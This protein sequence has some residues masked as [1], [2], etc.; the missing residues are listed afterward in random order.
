MAESYPLETIACSLCG[1]R[2]TKL[3]FEIDV[4][5]DQ[6][7]KYGANQFNMVT[8]KRCGLSFI[9]PR[10]TQ[11][12]LTKF[13]SFENT[14]DMQFI[15]DWFIDNS[16]TLRK[17][18]RRFLRVLKIGWIH[19]IGCSPVTENTIKLFDNMELMQKMGIRARKLAETSFPWKEISIGLVSFYQPFLNW[20]E[21]VLVVECQERGWNM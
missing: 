19:K 20:V 9:N 6:K 7:N 2:E 5:P 8:C 18:F 16:G 14:V 10:P 13:Y 4:R 17:N 11:E 3:L 1:S 21:R 12:S 15:N